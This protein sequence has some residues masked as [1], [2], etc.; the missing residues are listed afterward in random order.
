MSEL[1][2]GADTEKVWW[3][4]KEAIDYCD[5]ALDLIAESDRWVVDDEKW[6]TAE[7]TAWRALEN[8]QGWVEDMLNMLGGKLE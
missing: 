4:L 2:E 1:R 5:Q 8:A 3:M 6:D 7:L